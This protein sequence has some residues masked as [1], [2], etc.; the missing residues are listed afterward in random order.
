[1][2]QSRRLFTLVVFILLLTLPTAGNGIERR[3]PQF[4]T[5]TGYLIFPLPI[6]LPGIGDMV[7]VTGLAGNI[8]ETNID[9]YLLGITG[10]V[11]GFGLAVQDI[12]LMSETL[13]FDIFSQNLSKAT[14]NNYSTRGMDSEADDYTLLEATEINSLRSKLTLTL[15]DRR[16]EL[17]GSFSTQEVTIPRM[18]DSDGNMIAELSPPYHSESETTVFGSLVDYTDDH[19]DPRKG[20]RLQVSRS[21]TPNDDVDSPEFFVWDVNFTGYIPVGELSTIAINYY[22]SDT[23][24]IRVG[25]TDLNIL[26]QQLGI[27]CYGDPACEEAR[28]DLVRMIWSGNKYGT[29]SSLGGDVR[30]RSYPNGRFQGAHTRFYAAEFRWN[31]SEETQPFDWW[32][33]KDVRTGSQVAIFYETG[34]VADTVD[35][36]GDIYRSTYGLGYRLVTASGFVYRAELA[37]GEEGM[38][39]I[40]IFDY[41]W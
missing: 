10:D 36:L 32:V 39:T 31:L 26:E 23:D 9:A 30:L 11:E 38:S 28:E 24:V 19:Q 18:R 40:I 8:L 21:H 2:C 16:F 25:Q 4:Q 5:E 6:S 34:T 12:H 41:P 14:V 27:E 13:I 7:V 20:A 35:K 17:Y 22:Q 3:E 33:W 1:M 29:A 15:F 37:W